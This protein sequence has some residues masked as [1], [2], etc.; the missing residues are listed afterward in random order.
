MRA[1]RRVRVHLK[2]LDRERVDEVLS[3]GVQPVRTV[4]RALALSHLHDGKGTGEVA[5]TVRLTPK[6]VR[7]I[8][9][10]YEDAGLDTALYDKPRPGA[11]PLLDDSQRQRVIAMVCSDPPE[12]RAR[13][14]VRLVAEE[15]VKRKLVPPV[16]RETIRV[17]LLHHDLRPWR[18][19]NV[20]RGGTD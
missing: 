2:K 4:L 20:V 5:A 11:S 17:L 19:K 15:A 14:T 12:G 16:G 13:W 10:R 3:G 1:Y 9:R 8:G 6:A 7:Q 18:E